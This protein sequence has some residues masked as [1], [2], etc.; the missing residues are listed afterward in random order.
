MRVIQPP[1]LL[2]KEAASLKIRDFDL[3]IK[4]VDDDG[5]FTG[6]GSVFG[7]VDSYREIVAKG[8]FAD[9]L[10]AIK[11]KGRPVPVLWQHRSGQP[12]GVYDI[13]VDDDHGL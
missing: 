11:A 4:S 13:L 3:E 7:V 9:S 8:A 10:K 1:R 5:K 6:Y 12:I 2:R